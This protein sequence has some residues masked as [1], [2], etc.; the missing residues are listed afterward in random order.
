LQPRLARATTTDGAAIAYIVTG[1]GPTLIHLPGVPLSN[2]AAEWQIPSLE[3]AYRALSSHLRLVQCGGRG[4]GQSQRNV[5][6]VTLET[7][8]CDLEA[9]VETTGTH[10][11]APFGFYLSCSIVI[12]YAARH[13]ERVTGLTSPTHGLP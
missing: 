4:A 6:E 1:S 2:V 11:F 3:Q 12:A 5:D 10:R 9:V 8:L 7:M 13:P